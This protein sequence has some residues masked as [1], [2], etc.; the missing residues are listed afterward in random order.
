MHIFVI[1][2]NPLKA[3]RMKIIILKFSHNHRPHSDLLLYQKKFYTVCH[4]VM[5]V[6]SRGSFINIASPSTPSL[7]TQRCHKRR[8]LKKKPFEW[9][10]LLMMELFP[11]DGTNLM[12]LSQLSLE[13]IFSHHQHKTQMSERNVKVFRHYLLEAA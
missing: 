9:Q 3:S 4:K 10:F 12:L 2:F 1:H 6:Y 8:R 7:D 13:T 5:A 11:L